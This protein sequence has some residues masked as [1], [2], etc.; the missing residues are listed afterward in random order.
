M[1]T[2]G[3]K[4]C[5]IPRHVGALA[6]R[7]WHYSRMI[8]RTN[9]VY[10]FWRGS[11]FDGCIAFRRA[12]IGGQ[13]QRWWERVFDS[14]AIVELCRIALRAQDERPPT[15]RYI[16]MALAQV[17]ALGFDGVGS[18]ADTGQGHTGGVYRAASWT[19][20]PVGS[21]TQLTYADGLWQPNRVMPDGTI[22]RGNRFTKVTHKRR[23]AFGLTRR[24]RR[25]LRQ[26]VADNPAPDTGQA[27]RRRAGG[28]QLD[29]P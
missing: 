12:F 9:L 24:G 18:Y 19:E 21:P 16:S 2:D 3:L 7:H 27:A 29:W 11:T 15:T 13:A 26:W 17:R 6:C 23:Y 28:W 14:K 5:L 22:W 25:A 8:P 4:I 20:L 10:G 1:E